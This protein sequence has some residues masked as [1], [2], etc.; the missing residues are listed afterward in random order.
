M[1]LVGVVVEVP[2]EDVVTEGTVVERPVS[3]RVV[4]KADCF[5]DLSRHYTAE[6]G[7][8]ED[9]DPLGLLHGSFALRV[10]FTEC[11]SKLAFLSNWITPGRIT[12]TKS[13]VRETKTSKLNVYCTTL[14]CNF[15]MIESTEKWLA[16]SK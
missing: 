6:L 10:V 14:R 16:K 4:L 7:L 5:G 11:G 12:V 8:S 15:P 1:L 13:D 9:F 2:R 3:L